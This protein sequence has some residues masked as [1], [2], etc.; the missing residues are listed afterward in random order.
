MI[1]SL[2][3]KRRETNEQS[4]RIACPG[5]RTSRISHKV[6]SVTSARAYV[7]SRVS[8]RSRYACYI[9]QTWQTPQPLK[10]WAPDELCQVIPA[11]IMRRG[12]FRERATERN[13]EGFRCRATVTDLRS[14]CGSN[15]S[16]NRSDR[17]RRAAQ[18]RRNPARSAAPSFFPELH[19]REEKYVPR[20]RKG[21][22]SGESPVELKPHGNLDR[23]MIE[24]ARA[25]WPPLMP[26]RRNSTIHRRENRTAP[27]VSRGACGSCVTGL[28]F[29]T[30]TSR[31]RR[32][33]PGTSR[34]CRS[35]DPTG[36]APS[37]SRAPSMAARTRFRRRSISV[38]RDKRHTAR[39]VDVTGL[40]G[41]EMVSWERWTAWTGTAGIYLFLE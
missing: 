15:R 16:G 26:R 8:I 34:G 9:G 29:F 36:R 38:G 6:R 27:R 37:R 1:G 11:C 35:E 14:N 19:R 20:G 33:S 25:W 12:F 23:L 2:S 3:I 39:I 18:T 4:I 31:N 21:D 24:R 7:G 5:M 28:W 13:T 40:P 22:S 17:S 30:L 10:Y 41:N 32:R